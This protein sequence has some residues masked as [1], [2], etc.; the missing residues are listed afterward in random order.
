MNNFDRNI[1]ELL[2]SHTEQPSADCWN[3]INYQ[4]DMQ[5]MP[6]SN[7]GTSSSAS[8]GGNTSYFSQFVGSIT[9]K[10]VSAVVSVA[11]IGGIIA[12]IAVNYAQ[13]E[14]KIENETA[15]ILEDTQN[16][17]VLLNEEDIENT[18]EIATLSA[19]DENTA[20]E[21]EIYIS[22]EYK[23]TENYPDNATIPILNIVPNVAEN[24]SVQ[25]E[26]ENTAKI[27]TTPKTENKAQPTAKGREPK[28]RI[29]VYSNKIEPVE[30]VAENEIPQNVVELPKFTIPNVFTPNGSDGKRYYFVIEGI[31]QF[32]ENH[33]HIYN[34][35]GTVVYEKSNYKNDWGAEN[36][37]V[38]V[39]YYI[40]TFVHQGTQSMRSGSITVRR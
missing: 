22:N 21:N 1:Q 8:S 20:F 37:P 14:P 2:K 7:A 27:E 15:V 38:G 9:G 17:Y 5:Q 30:D 19:R 31:E 16:E 39:Y 29:F 6:D 28:R 35:H 40:F 36:L 12:L 3:R 4:L 32:T 33:L 10:V 24:Q 26:T 18:N 23:D 13:D 11:A 25:S 34:R